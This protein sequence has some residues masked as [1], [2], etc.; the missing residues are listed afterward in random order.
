MSVR[1]HGQTE[2]F[3]PLGHHMPEVGFDT[4]FTELKRFGPHP[5]VRRDPDLNRGG[6]RQDQRITRRF[7]FYLTHLL[8][9]VIDVCRKA[10]PAGLE[11]DAPRDLVTITSHSAELPLLAAA[12]F[13]PQRMLILHT[14]DGVMSRQADMQ[15]QKCG[16]FC[17]DVS[18][19]PLRG[20]PDLEDD[21][22]RQCQNW[23]SLAPPDRRFILDLTPGRKDMSFALTRLTSG[24]VE[25]VYLTHQFD[26]MM[27]R[28]VPF[29]ERY[30]LLQPSTLRA[31]GGGRS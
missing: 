15:K 13:R 25:S 7:K 4:R 11:A 5:V 16:R 17:S 14:D 6:A 10:L 24:R 29:T 19:A 23:F 8:D 20:W 22:V 2:C 31:D 21:V 27:R 3:H 9:D 26:G 30:R 18:T 28:S 12:V 1:N